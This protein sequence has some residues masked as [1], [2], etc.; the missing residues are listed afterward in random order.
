MDQESA[1]TGLPSVNRFLYMYV[2]EITL[3][4]DRLV[5]Y[6]VQSNAALIVS[7]VGSA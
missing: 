4:A 1:D 2:L 3:R 7:R 6:D 5:F